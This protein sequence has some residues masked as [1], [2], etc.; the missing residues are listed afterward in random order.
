MHNLAAALAIT[1]SYLDGRSSN[2]TEDDDVEVLEAVAAE[3]Q[4]APSDEKNVVISALVH[5]G[6][7]DLVDGL[8]LN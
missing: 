6:R 4:N 3:L 5:I 7:A 2:S 1:P 8:G